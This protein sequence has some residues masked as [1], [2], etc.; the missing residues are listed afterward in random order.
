MNKVIYIG[1]VPEQY[2]EQFGDE[3]QYFEFNDKKFYYALEFNFEDG[4]ATLTDTCGRSMPMD[5]SSYEEI[6]FAMAELAALQNTYQDLQDEMA[7]FIDAIPAT[8]YVRDVTGQ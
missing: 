2:L 3:G 5:Y 6:A 7:D 4:C 8:T 1:E